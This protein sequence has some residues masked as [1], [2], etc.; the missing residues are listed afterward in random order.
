MLSRGWLEVDLGAVVRNARALT[1]RSGVP[2]IPMVKADAYGMG[3]VAVARPVSIAAR[4]ASSRRSAGT[5]SS[6]TPRRRIAA[7]STGL[8]SSNNGRLPARPASRG[9]RC[10]PPAPGSRPSPTS[11]RP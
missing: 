9:S 10:V 4:A 1:E 5:T 7:A 11:G 3:A 6:N 8:P 2:L